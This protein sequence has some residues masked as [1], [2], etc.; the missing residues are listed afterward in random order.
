MIDLNGLTKQSYQ[1]AYQR[2]RNG[3]IISTDTLRMLKHCAGEVIEATDCYA[4]R[5][6]DGFVHEL[7][8]VI[9]C[10]LII[11]GKHNI[12]I[13]KALNDCHEKNRRRAEKQGDKL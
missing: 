7:S 9:M 1:T 8:D 5:H 10:C 11:A 4:V 3:A 13:E 2:E 6:F 12:D